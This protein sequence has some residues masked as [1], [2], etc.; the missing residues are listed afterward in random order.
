[1][2]GVFFPQNSQVSISVGSI[3][4]Y[5]IHHGSKVF[6]NK[7]QK[8]P[9]GKGWICHVQ[10]PFYKAFTLNW[11]F[12]LGSEGKESDC[13][14]RRPGFNP[15]VRDIPWRRKWWPISIF[16]P[17]ESPWTEKPGGVQS[18]GSQRVGHSWATKHHWQGVLESTPHGYQG[19]QFL[20]KKA[21][22]SV[23]GS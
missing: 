1:M 21:F 7:F 20:P 17:G 4:T 5:S 8:V 19:I 12:P 14:W 23:I 3:S 13:Q 9:K 22:S 10:E 2:F 16:L 18:M 15:W 11:D 6:E